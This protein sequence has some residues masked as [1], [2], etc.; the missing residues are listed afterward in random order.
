MRDSTEMKFVCSLLR[1]GKNGA[2]VDELRETTNDRI[3]V[4]IISATVPY[5][6]LLDRDQKDGSR[7]SRN[8]N[9]S[10]AIQ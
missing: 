5:E 3:T 9:R 1:T 4:L 2:S 10:G 8:L 6:G 7:M